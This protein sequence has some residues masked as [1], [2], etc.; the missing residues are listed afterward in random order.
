MWSD[1]EIKESE[2]QSDKEERIHYSAYG[3][4]DKKDVVYSQRLT[5][6]K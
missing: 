4:N 6:D 5:K 3:L 1:N 2:H